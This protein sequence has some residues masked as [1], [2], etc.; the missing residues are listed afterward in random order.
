MNLL[1]LETKKYNRLF[2]KIRNI[3]RKLHKGVL[4]YN[5]T[6]FYGFFGSK[7]V[8]EGYTTI[9]KDPSIHEL[10]IHVEII[11]PYTNAYTAYIKVGNMQASKTYSF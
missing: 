7:G 10:D 8:K 11:Q 5:T 3:T 4:Q 2:T 6:N 9:L 1:V